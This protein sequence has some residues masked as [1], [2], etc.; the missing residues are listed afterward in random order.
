MREAVQ[1]CA[2]LELWAIALTVMWSEVGR[3][4]RGVGRR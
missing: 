3:M 2:S 1:A 4:R